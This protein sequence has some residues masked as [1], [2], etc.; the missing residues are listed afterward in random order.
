VGRLHG[1]VGHGQ[2]LAGQAVQ[3]DLLAQSAAD[4][5]R[6]NRRSTA[7]WMRRRMGWNT[8]SS[9]TSWA[10]LVDPRAP[11][12]AATPVVTLA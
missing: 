5:R 2:Q 12:T 7:A 11:G 4:R 8:A 3:V 9:W 1:L 10:I 6:L